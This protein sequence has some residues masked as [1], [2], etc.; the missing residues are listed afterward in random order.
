MMCPNRSIGGVVRDF[1][2]MLQEEPASHRLLFDSV[3]HPDCSE[4]TDAHV[5]AVLGETISPLAWTLVGPA[6]EWSQARMWGALGVV[7]PTRDRRARFSARLQGR[8]H[9]GLSTLR[10]A[11]G[12][13]PGIAPERTE[14]ELGLPASNTSKT[15]ADR[16]WY[17][18]AAAGIATTAGRAPLWV[19]RQRRLVA[20][21]VSS[22]PGP[23]AS[24]AELIARIERLR[25]DLVPVLQAHAFVRMSTHSAIERLRNDAGD[26]ELAF[27]LLANLPELEASQPSLALVRIARVL[28]D[29]GDIPEAALDDFLARYGHRGV[30]ELDPTVPVWAAQRPELLAQI[31]RLASSDVDDPLLVA[32]ARH[33]SAMRRAA[34]LGRLQ[35]Q[36]VAVDARVARMLSVLGERSKSDVARLVNQIRMALAPLRAGLPG[37]LS[38]ELETM[39]GWREL[40]ARYDSRAAIPSDLEHRWGAFRRCLEGATSTAVARTDRLVGVA[41]APGV[42]IGE[43]VVIADPSDDHAEGGI[44]VADATDTAWTPLFI[45]RSAVVTNT[46]GVL[47]HSSIVARDL[48]IPAV[49]GTGNATV[50]IPPGATTRVDGDRGVVDLLVP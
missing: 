37:G 8:L 50:V 43:A 33:Q 28:R 42:A 26:D 25:R 29:T 22:T 16:L 41:A 30:N 15:V 39:V 24:A 23:G 18:V 9:V 5:D 6:F 49:V 38:P 12:R 35:G 3:T 27:G 21:A 14:R 32:S 7:P 2:C 10:R 17:P 20:R 40:R 36:R 11:A 31:E 48:G 34:Q 44:L 1:E 45:G 47:S 4:W 19:R 46:G 13:I